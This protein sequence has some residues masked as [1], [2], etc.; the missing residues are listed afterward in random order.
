[1]NKKGHVKN[2]FPGA[3]TYKGF[4]SF[5]D[6]IMSQKDAGRIFCMKGGPGVGKSTFMKKVAQDFIDRGYDVELHHCSSDNNSLDGV[7]I[8]EPRIV[9]LDGTAPHIVDPK[10]PGAVD[11]VVN[12]G[13]FWNEEGFKEERETIINCNN[14]IRKFFFSA[15]HYLA[16]AKEMQDDIENMTEEALDQVAYTK[17]LLDLK[18]ELLKGYGHTELHASI[19]HL[20]DSAV[21]PDGIIDYV[22]TIIPEDY[23]CYYLKGEFIKQKSEVLSILAKEYVNL[24]YDVELYHQPLNPERLQTLVVKKLKVAL[25]VHSK[26]EPV[27]KTI[28]F[29][30]LLDSEKLA[31]RAEIIEKDK[32]FYGLLLA[33]GVKRIKAAK[34]RHDELEKSYIPQ[35]NFEA[36]TAYRDKF[37]ERVKKYL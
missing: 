29:E 3:N 20:F 24:G 2:V 37:I 19:R 18:T 15:Y 23:C 28:D 32:E 10:N 16:S 22:D 36:L 31:K 30:K 17:V 25:T 14:D 13:D 11:E 6:Y 27:A 26:M 8:V 7:V 35:M 5:Y 9:I 4:H 21:T 33:E 34:T 12:L 1:M